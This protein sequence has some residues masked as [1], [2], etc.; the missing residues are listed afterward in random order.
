M[1]LML[2]DLNIVFP[3][4]NLKKKSMYVG[5]LESHFNKTAHA[6]LPTVI[7]C[8]ENLLEILLETNIKLPTVCNFRKLT[9]KYHLIQFRN[10]ITYLLQH[11]KTIT[12]H[13]KLL[14]INIKMPTGYS[15]LQ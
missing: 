5:M 10:C 8:F 14:N 1:A 13:I 2:E 9:I 4:S 6:C 11:T 15:R 3:M 7:T 12:H